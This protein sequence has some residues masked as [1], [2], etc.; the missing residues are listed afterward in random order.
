MS[1][2]LHPVRLF[3][4]V[5]RVAHAHEVKELFERMVQVAGVDGRA[6]AELVRAIE[7]LSTGVRRA[8]AIASTWRWA[9]LLVIALGVVCLMAVWLTHQWAWVWGSIV[10][11]VI[12]LAFLNARIR[13]ADLYTDDV[14][15]V[16]ADGQRA[17]CQSMARLNEMYDWGFVRG[18]LKRHMPQVQFDP[19]VSHGRLNDLKESFGWDHSFNSD[20]S[21][22]NAM[23]GELN[24]NPFVI[25][26]FRRHWMGQETYHGSLGISWVEYVEEEQPDGRRERKAVTRHETLTASVTASVPCYGDH[27][28]V[29]FGHAAAPDLKF[30]RE[31]S[32][33][34]SSGN[35]LFSRWRR[36]AAMRSVQ[37][38]GRKGRLQ[39]MSNLE[40]DAL[41]AAFDRN[42][43]QQFRLL[44][45]PLAQQEMLQIL[46]DRES[47]FGDDFTFTKIGSINIVEA[48]HLLSAEFSSDPALFQSDDL[49]RA[50][51]NFIDYHA[52]AFRS[53]FFALAPIL[54]IPIYHES[55]RCRSPFSNATGRMLGFWEHEAIAHHIGEERLRSAA[56]A[57]K[58][59]MRASVVRLDSGGET[60]RVTAH[61]YRAVPRVEL[62]SVG[63]GDGRVHEVPVHWTEYVPDA[64]TT[65]MRMRAMPPEQSGAAS[66]R[67]ET[68][69][70]RQEMSALGVP[71]DQ[72]LVRHSV[73]IA[74]LPNIFNPPR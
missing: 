17:A 63:G 27:A 70:W 46:R 72:V 38:M 3:R 24:G 45:T 58:C 10:A 66:M 65:I 36:A 34:S 15:A 7:T 71:S 32:P 8:S 53:V 22:L 47:G 6:N 11:A 40:F 48:M 69:A 57:T 61:G 49:A 56:C 4:Q 30:R 74:M 50:R 73:L 1:D 31:P 25:G 13:A 28:A 14:R 51:Q 54:A 19:Y 60:V 18:M 5:A 41:F 39:P 29:V 33:H 21:V 37:R 43:E 62:V 16:L 23:S 44:F 59:M 9:R 55:R 68:A 35:G 26:Q 52:A 2:T 12:V 42:N 64:K 20:L 67:R